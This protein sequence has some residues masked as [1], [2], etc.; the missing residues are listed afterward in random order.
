M[1]P[2]ALPSILT[3]KMSL[4]YST[5]SLAAGGTL[6]GSPPSN[7]GGDASGTDAGFEIGSLDGSLAM[8]LGSDAGLAVGLDDGF[9][10][11]LDADFFP[12]DFE[13]DGFEALED[14]GVPLV[15][16]LAVFSLLAKYFSTYVLM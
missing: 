16:F 9:A 7:D 14:V 6:D 12:D 11:D 15:P 5:M 4:S 3:F 13:L 2:I 1:N 8:V 10:L